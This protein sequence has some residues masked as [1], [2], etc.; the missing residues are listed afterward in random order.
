MVLFAARPPYFQPPSCL[1][2]QFSFVYLQTQTYVIALVLLFFLVT[3]LS[4]EH[5]LR[6]LQQWLRKKGREGLVMAVEKMV[7][8]I[9]LLGLVSLILLLF[10]QYVP[11]IC[12]TYSDKD[13]S[14]TL[15]NNTGGCP[16]CMSHT[17]GITTCAQMYHDCAFNVTDKAPYCG[18]SLGWPESTP[19]YTFNDLE[20][21]E[22]NV[23]L[24]VPGGECLAYGQNEVIFIFEQFMDSFAAVTTELNTS[25]AE[26]CDILI[27]D[28]ATLN[29]NSTSNS[30]AV[31][32]MNP[33]TGRRRLMGESSSP[34]AA[35]RT[36]H[37]IPEVKTFQC[38][39]PFYASSCGVG[40][41]PAISNTALNQI[42]LLVFLIAAFHIVSAIV[43]MLVATLR[44]RQWRRWQDD[45]FDRDIVERSM[46]ALNKFRASLRRTRLRADGPTPNVS[47]RETRD[48]IERTADDTISN[49]KSPGA[50]EEFLEEQG[51]AQCDVYDPVS[52][53][54][55]VRDSNKASEFGA[56]AVA[57]VSNAAT[58]VQRQWVRRDSQIQRKR[59]WIAEAVVC[60]GKALFPNL[61]SR[62]EFN[63]MRQAYIVSK[64]DL[65]ADYDF[66]K[67]LQL[68]LD[69][70]FV[71]ILGASLTMWICLLF[72][73]LL[74]GLI[75]WIPALLLLFAVLGLF[76][77]DIGLVAVVRHQCRG[78]RPH[79][80]EGKGK[81]YN[82]N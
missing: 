21:P 63:M 66:V 69:F 79:R 35:S 71:H 38:E 17:A 32:L 3:S 74:S 22:L 44:M 36:L 37:I 58:S 39:G 28:E 12:M 9:T 20:D 24:S 25:V 11:D 60:V 70:D 68:H 41:H 7:M 48:D 49:N 62:E 64:P 76:A 18:C 42:H 27:E 34:D 19:K 2:L 45:T 73:W 67:D 26:W 59:H 23:N 65:P 52:N 6:A 50:A 54:S 1:L 55:E 29:L 81:Q 80:Y 33:T 15:L 40:K 53:P 57:A 46:S 14:W 61:V 47:A 5:G 30:T 4:F 10:Q 13:I 77:I 43:V 72:M 78:G 82:F 51:T 31:A 8:E 56:A 16:C 75:P